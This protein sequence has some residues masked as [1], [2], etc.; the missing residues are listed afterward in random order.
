M[1]GG[2]AKA[3]GMRGRLEVL[4]AWPGFHISQT[5]HVIPQDPPMSICTNPKTDVNKTYPL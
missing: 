3:R 4:Q 2:E 5:M 1:A